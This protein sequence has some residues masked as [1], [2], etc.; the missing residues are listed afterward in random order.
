MSARSSS[1]MA[2]R[3]SLPPP[4]FSSAVVIPRSEES[5]CQGFQGSAGSHE[6]MLPPY[7][8]ALE[9]MPHQSQQR[10]N[11]S[12]GGG[13]PARAGGGMKLLPTLHLILCMSWFSTI[14]IK[15]KNGLPGELS[16]HPPRF[17]IQD[18]PQDRQCHPSSDFLEG[19]DR[20]PSLP[21]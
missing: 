5:K 13:R 12:E 1:N 9:P 4:A 3:V 8:T 16:R 15:C 18:A 14:D 17:Q 19:Q 7:S 11:V 2:P 6:Q 20:Q 10:V 21:I